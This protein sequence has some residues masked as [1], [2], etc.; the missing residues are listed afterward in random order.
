MPYFALLLG[1]KCQEPC[2]TALICKIY[3]ATPTVFNLSQNTD[4]NNQW[5]HSAE[6]S[7]HAPGPW[8][9]FS[10]LNSRSNTPRKAVAI[11]FSSFLCW[12][13]SVAW[14]VPLLIVPQWPGSRQINHVKHLRCTYRILHL[15]DEYFK[16]LRATVLP[17]WLPFSLMLSHEN[18]FTRLLIIEVLPF[19]ILFKY[20]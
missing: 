8:C 18:S 4:L 3:H 12:W 19:G 16:S 13:G 11:H 2:K 6:S 10:G 5:K 20:S 14:I 7:L 17:N 9:L 1:L 15:L